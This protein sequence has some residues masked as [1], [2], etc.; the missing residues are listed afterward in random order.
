M[1]DLGV[2]AIY[3][4]RGDRYRR[5]LLDIAGVKA[6]C[7][8]LDVGCGPGR[9]ALAACGRV[10]TAGEAHGVD[11][12]A[13]M[14]ALA[15]QKAASAGLSA[16][17]TRAAAEGLPFGDRYFD[18]VTSS[19][20]IHHIEGEDLRRRAFGEMRRVSKDGGRVLVVDFTVPESG[21]LRPLIGMLGTHI[22]ATTLDGYPELMEG[23]GLDPRETGEA[24]FKMFRY[25]LCRAG[26]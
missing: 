7:R 21:L 23:A 14:V 10:G 20:V 17:F 18:V 26:R 5:R 24:E 9:L 6:G 2:E 8:V 22:H 19:L 4:G 13:E 25:F 11:P 12:S 16:R 3:L 1:Y 15:T